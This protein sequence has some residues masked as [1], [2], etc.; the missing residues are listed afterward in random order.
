[1]KSNYLD[2][3]VIKTIR[4]KEQIRHHLINGDTLIIKSENEVYLI[5]E[6]L[7]IGCR[8]F[9]EDVIE[10]IPKT[11]IIYRGL[12]EKEETEYHS[13]IEAIWDGKILEYL[14][15]PVKERIILND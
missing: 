14:I 6:N 1:M 2:L 3:V 7:W 15:K 8:V 9:I 13:Y 4:E 12:I 5:P 11:K 10:K